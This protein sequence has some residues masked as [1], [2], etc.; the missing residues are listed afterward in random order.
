M[1]QVIEDLRRLADVVIID[2]PP[3]FLADT[4]VLSGKVDGMLLVVSLGHTHKKS[5]SKLL[6]QTQR[7]GA[8][9]IGVVLNRISESNDYPGSYYYH[10]PKK[11]VA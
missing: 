10:S 3:F 11:T 2:S 4:V 5:I 8:N 1:T 7:L 9:L 6:D